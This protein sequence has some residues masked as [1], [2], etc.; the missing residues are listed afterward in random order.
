MIPVTN[1]PEKTAL[2]RKKRYLLSVSPMRNRDPQFIRPTKCSESHKNGSTVC[3]IF[4]LTNIIRT[5][6]INVP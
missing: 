6:P 1:T 5:I 3:V 4:E 2:V